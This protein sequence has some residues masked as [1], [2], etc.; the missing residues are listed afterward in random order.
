M[1]DSADNHYERAFE[2]WLID[3]R[4]QYVRADEHKRL[5]PARRSVKNFDFLLHTGSSRQIIAEVKGRTF[6]GTTVAQLKGLDC[7]VTRDDVEGLQMWQRA[8]GAGHEAAFIFAYRVVNVDVD[9][10]GRETLLLDQDRYL[11]LAVRVDDYARHMKRRSP[12]W[13]T[14][15]LPAEKFR[16]LAVDLVALL[17]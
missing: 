4:V 1:R 5:G 11:F 9:F 8:L 7:W 14:V 16:E 12:K 2:S 15:T 3:H 10:D 6:K 17:R 13:Q